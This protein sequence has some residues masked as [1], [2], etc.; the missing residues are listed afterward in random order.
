VPTPPLPVT[1]RRR[2]LMRP[3]PLLPLFQIRRMGGSPGPA[4]PATF[5]V[6][7]SSPFVSQ[8]P[9]EILP[10]QGADIYKIKVS[11]SALGPKTRQ[12]RVTTAAL[13][14]A[15]GVV[16]LDPVALP[17]GVTVHGV[18]EVPK[19]MDASGRRLSITGAAKLE[20][21][22]CG[23]V[24]QIDAWVVPSL[25]VSLLLGTPFLYRYTKAILPRDKSVWVRNPETEERWLVSLLSKTDREK[26]GAKSTAFLKVAADFCIAPLTEQV[27]LVGS[28]SAGL[29]LITPVQRR[30]SPVFTANCLID[31]PR[32]GTATMLVVN[33]S[34]EPLALRRCRVT[35]KAEEPQA[36]LVVGVY[37]TGGPS[38]CVGHQ[39]NPTVLGA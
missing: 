6:A 21:T 14:T 24:A 32:E 13:D 30:R 5:V 28:D 26:T 8:A 11:M 31:L 34:D 29:S 33:F 36:V 25:P 4:N 16:F 1:Y 3:N 22:I 12:M 35:G 7:L 17:Q 23:L 15:A 37:Q 9:R 38:S 27:I 20:V 18:E 10:L 19:I 2:H 39:A